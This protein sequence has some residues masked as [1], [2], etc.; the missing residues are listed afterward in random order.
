MV[1]PEPD[2]K[3]VLLLRPFQ[4]PQS[5][6][7]PELV[8]ARANSAPSWVQILPSFEE[9]QLIAPADNSFQEKSTNSD[10]HG[11]CCTLF[12]LLELC[13]IFIY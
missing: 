8:R 9:W 13:G 1:L 5:F 10:W 4:L 7:N 3:T 2:L 6:Q 11:F 12:Q